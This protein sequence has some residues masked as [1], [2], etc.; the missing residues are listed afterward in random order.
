MNYTNTLPTNANAN[1]NSTTTATTVATTPTPSPDTAP[2]RRRPFRPCPVRPKVLARLDS[3]RTLIARL[4]DERCGGSVPTVRAV[5]RLMW[6]AGCDVA[7]G[8]VH[9]DMR[10]LKLVGW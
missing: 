1:A 5:Q 7:L 3:R 2:R 8:T 4:I 10:A 9:T 6:E